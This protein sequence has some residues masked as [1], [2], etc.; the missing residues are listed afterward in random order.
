MLIDALI[1]ARVSHDS[2]GFGRSVEEQVA[3]G[4][5]WAEQEGWDVV[6]VIRETGSASRFS[7]RRERVEWAEALRLIG[8]G[9]IGILLT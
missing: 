6:R 8:D 5:K 9:R 1:F 7:S 3:D 4:L 2:S